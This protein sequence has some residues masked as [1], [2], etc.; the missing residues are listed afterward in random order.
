MPFFAVPPE[1]P[2]MSSDTAGRSRRRAV[3]VAF[4]L[5]ATGFVL[6]IPAGFLVA[7]V[8]NLAVGGEIGDVALLGI[9]MLALQGIAFPATAW[10]YV[11]YRGVAWSYV[12]ASLPDVSDL[13]YVAGSYVAVFAVIYAIS[14]VLTLTS[15]E[16]AS[17]TGATTALQNPEIIPYLIPLQLLLIG[18]GEELLFRGIIQ[19][20]LRE[21]FDAWPSILLASMA[22]APLHI[23]A[24]SGSLSAA[25]V[26]I[27]ILFV[28]SIA[29]GYI[30]EKTGNI[31][32]PALA[33]GLYN[34]TLFTLMYVVVK[35][36]PESTSE[37]AGLLGVIA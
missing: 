32:V 8:Y 12:P 26:T 30:Y 27:G 29:F 22:F 11:R 17:N 15:T 34:G 1:A 20:R 35:Y 7:N 10:L 4:G 31:V 5:A 37:A 19:S 2:A 14:V 16:A 6:A 28:P 13:K 21:Q 24:L 9:G 36:A 25:A 33:H 23:F 18:P 3:L